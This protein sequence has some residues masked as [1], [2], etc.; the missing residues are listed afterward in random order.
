MNLGDTGKRTNVFSVALR[1][2][3]MFLNGASQILDV[4]ARQFQV[5]GQSF[6]ALIDA[7]APYCTARSCG[8]SWPSRSAR[9]RSTIPA[10]ARI[11][12]PSCWETIFRSLQFARRYSCSL[13]YRAR[14]S[15]RD[16]KVHPLRRTLVF[17]LRQL[18]RHYHLQHV[19]ARGNSL[20]QHHIATRDQALSI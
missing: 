12:S 13:A 7:H 9:R 6:K 16:F 14:R 3:F 8:Y 10:S 18:V 4:A 2:D 5:H 15:T 19:I 11:S 1:S 20:R 17:L